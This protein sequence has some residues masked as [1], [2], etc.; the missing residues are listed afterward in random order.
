M[1]S[2]AANLGMWMHDV[3]AAWLMTS[4]SPSPIMVA[5]IQT[6]TSL[7]F[8]LLAVPAGALADVLDR[9]RMLLSTH[10]WMVVAAIV[11]AGLTM[12]GLTT[13]AVL[14]VCTFILGL[15]TAM[16]LPSWQATIPELV[17]R[18]EVPAAVTLHGVA[19][20]V[21]RAA[22]PAV[23][24]LIVAAVGSGPVFLLR[25]ALLL[26]ATV[27]IYRWRRRRPKRTSPPEH[28]IG[29][30]RAG[31]RYVRYAPEFR[32]GL[33]R[34]GAF[35]LCASALWALLPLLGRQEMGLGAIGYGG[36]LGCMGIGAV[37]G[38][39]ILPRVQRRTSIDLVMAVA[40]VIFAVVMAL[41]A[42]VRHYAALC[43]VMLVGGVAW[44]ALM[45][46]A[47]VAAQMALP[48][49]VRARAMAVHMLVFQGGMAVGSVA[50]GALAT[51]GGIPLA[52]LVAAGGL[53]VGL[54]ATR[55][56]RLAID[57][58]V[59]LKPSAHWPEPHVVIEPD[60]DQ[61]PVMV[62]VEY[63]IDPKRAPDFIEAMAAVEQV[64]RRDGAFQWGLFTD[65][66]DPGRYV[67]TFFSESWAEHLRQHERATVADRA[68]DEHAQAF[69]VGATP[70][71]ISHFI[72]A[73]RR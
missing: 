32:G 58:T 44:I 6:A 51:R 14:L 41:L 9:R 33:V 8:F 26:I 17:S 53:V 55:R 40:T 7:P 69:H 39:A 3:A 60:P 34:T 12:T 35:I 63:R 65:T 18:P 59:D 42:E 48:S 24:G 56:Y 46:N 25:A 36:L 62:T 28:L 66:D 31:L 4:L 15:G 52:L 23:G 70:P 61:G 57:A 27:P 10:A 13:P 43:A 16:I 11:L 73:S 47:V 54:A 37:A 49:W 29:A 21:A 30:V 50:W 67:E 19:F 22:G 5:L 20:N 38:A 68:S 45:S 2:V 71:L 1:A 72:A 64:R